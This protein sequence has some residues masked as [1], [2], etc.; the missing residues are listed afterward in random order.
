MTI[1]TAVNWKERIVE[2]VLVKQT[3]DELDTRGLWEYHLPG[4]AAT[5]GQLAAVETTLGEPLD[6]GLRSFLEHAGG[7]P[8]LWQTVDL[9]GP[10]DLL[11]SNRFRRATEMLGSVEDGVLTDGGLRRADLLPIAASPVDADLFVMTRQS[12]PSPGCVVWLAG[13]EVDRWPTF[14]A[15]FL[16]MIDYNRL[17]LQH[18]QGSVG[19]SM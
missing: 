13:A 9:F 1:E 4:V 16:A 8:A 10:G 7:W 14:E 18:L 17:E 19:D 15:F 2:L 11:G 3:I 6:P 5:P 12:S